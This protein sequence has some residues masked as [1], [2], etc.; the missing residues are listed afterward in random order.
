M[1]FQELFRLT[2]KL[3]IIITFFSFVLLVNVSFS[4]INCVQN[5]LIAHMITFQV[6]WL[7]TILSFLIIFSLVILYIV[8]NSTNN[9]R[10]LLFVKEE[11]AYV[12]LVFGL[13]ILSD[14]FFVPL[15][16]FMKDTDIHSSALN[17]M[18]KVDNAQRNYIKALNSFAVSSWSDSAK[19][20]YRGWFI[21]EGEGKL[22]FDSANNKANYY[23]ADSL[24]NFLVAAQISTNVQLILLQ[25]IDQN[26][27]LIIFIIGLIF[28]L[29][30]GMRD[31]GNV[32]FAIGISIYFLVPFI[33]S[34]YSYYEQQIR[35]V[36][37]SSDFS[38]CFR[39]SN[40]F[41]D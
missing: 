26:F 40:N 25:L 15:C 8:A 22:G 14:L 10:L 29:I 7:F 3:L 13:I 31:F 33:Y 39:I 27:L 18:L 37:T 32:F 4:Q 20:Y 35:N 1:V 11:I 28:K 19:Y 9:I 12:F 34:N 16:F 23:F 30:P 5:T 2:K 17:F 41:I 36:I 38:A 6:S 24:L 21:W